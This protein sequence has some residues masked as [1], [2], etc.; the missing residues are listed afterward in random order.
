MDTAFPPAPLPLL[1]GS[2]PEG[3]LAHR[4]H[5]PALPPLTDSVAFSSL[6]ARAWGESGPGSRSCL[7]PSPGQA[8]SKTRCERGQPRGKRKRLLLTHHSGL[9]LTIKTTELL[10]AGA[11]PSHLASPPICSNRRCCRHERKGAGHGGKAR[12]QKTERSPQALLREA[13]ILGGAL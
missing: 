11:P 8:S 12:R 10:H 13:F 7:A 3:V 2:P 5:R 9:A 1:P 4:Q 6:E